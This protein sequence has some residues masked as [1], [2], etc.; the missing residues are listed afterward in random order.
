MRPYD[1]L[2]PTTPQYAAGRST[3]PMVCVP[4]A[5]GTCPAATA[6]ALP[7]LEPPGVRS[8]SSGLYVGAGSRCA[9]A[10]VCV[11]PTGTAPA[12]R[13]AAT[14]HASN[15]LTRGGRARPQAIG[16]ARTSMMS[17]TPNGIPE[18]GPAAA[19]ASA[20]AAATNVHACSGSP[21]TPVRL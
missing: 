16:I 6:A 4:S 8:A 17:L 14:H 2:K 21:S 15:S 7:A 13:S 10:V 18:S 5:N 20:A 3:E 19:G 1:G 12:A 11:L 9:H